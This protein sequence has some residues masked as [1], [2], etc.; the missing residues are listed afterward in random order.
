[1]YTKYDLV[2]TQERKEWGGG[3]EGAWT[4]SLIP[5]YECDSKLKVQLAAFIS[6][7]KYTT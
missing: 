7:E 3:K 4:F 1:M 6:T 5:Q 2:L